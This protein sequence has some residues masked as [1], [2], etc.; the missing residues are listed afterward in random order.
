VL[1]LAAASGGRALAQGGDAATISETGSSTGSK[2]PSAEAVPRIDERTAL[3]VGARRLKLGVVFFEYGVTEHLSVGTQPVGWAV[4]AFAPVVAPNLNV[5]YQF[6]DRDPVW[7]SAMVAGYYG[8]I[9]RGQ[10]SGEVLVA[11]LSL[12]ASVRPVRRLYLHAEGTYVFARAFGDGDLS[13]AQVGGT[14]VARAVQTQLMAE[15]RVL[16]WLSLIAL[17]RGQPYTSPIRASGTSQIDPFTTA[18]VDAE[19][20]PRIEHP[21]VIAGGVAL[22]FQHFHLAV[23]VGYGTYFVPGIDVPLQQR[24]FVP[25]GSLAVLFTP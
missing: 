16:Q 7:L 24:G 2:S 20:A 17:G 6:V 13:Q 5:K 22:L 21:W 25:D 4:R 19:L 10:G 11:P 18:S 1:V 8:N 14:L 3:M 23:G 9:S 12:F 15:V